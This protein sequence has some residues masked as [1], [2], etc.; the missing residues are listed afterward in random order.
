MSR[1][2]RGTR[3]RGWSL[4][5]PRS[6]RQARAASHSGSL[7]GLSLQPGGPGAELPQVIDGSFASVAVPALMLAISVP[8]EL[9]NPEPLVLV[10]DVDVSAAVDQDVLGLLDEASHRLRPVA[11]H[12]IGWNE[13]SDF[14]R[15]R[16]VGDVVDA[17]TG[18][19]VGQVHQRVRMI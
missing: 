1:T 12:R 8:V 5:R 6:G 2:S 13:P 11:M 9:E 16:G 15:Q 17:E 10:R 14:L 3:A 7:Q 19:E 18:I 4:R